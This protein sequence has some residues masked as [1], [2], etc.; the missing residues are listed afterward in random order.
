L[1][2]GNVALRRPGIKSAGALN[3][4]EI[5]LHEKSVAGKRGARASQAGNWIGSGPIAGRRF[6]A[7][8]YEKKQ[9]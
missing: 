6:A 4:P 7:G 3:T 5:K 8:S 9:K 2:A 1:G